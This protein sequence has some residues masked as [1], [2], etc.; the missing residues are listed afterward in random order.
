[1][2]VLDGAE[3]NGLV[4]VY[5]VGV[6]DRRHGVY[7]VEPDGR[8][9][10]GRDDFPQG[11]PYVGLGPYLISVRRRDVDLA[12][13]YYPRLTELVPEL[14]G[15]LTYVSQYPDGRGLRV[16]YYGVRLSGLSADA[17]VSY[18]FLLAEFAGLVVCAL[19]ISDID[20]YGLLR[21]S[22]ALYD[23]S[24]VV[25]GAQVISSDDEATATVPAPQLIQA[26]NAG[27]A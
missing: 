16:Q 3:Y 14:S 26:P 5:L 7:E 23:L 12:P 13:G 21:T 8:G 11:V 25:L 2:R 15:Q 4:L 19:H 20:A 27:S 10:Q 1:M 22:D 24:Q 17:Y 18:Q 9:Q 6:V